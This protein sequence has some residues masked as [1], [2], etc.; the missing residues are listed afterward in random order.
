MSLLEQLTEYNGLLDVEREVEEQH[1]M[2][3]KPFE[4]KETVG[5]TRPADTLE[6]EAYNNLI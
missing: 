4:V 6:A 3:R 5:L 1:F 2:E